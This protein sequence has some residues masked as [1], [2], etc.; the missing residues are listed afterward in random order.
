[1]EEF[2]KTEFE[3]LRKIQDL[4]REVNATKESISRIEESLIE[5]WERNNNVNI[6]YNILDDDNREK[7]MLKD[8]KVGLLFI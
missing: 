3:Y 6:L 5:F 8:V 4:K 7:I 2:K 1:M